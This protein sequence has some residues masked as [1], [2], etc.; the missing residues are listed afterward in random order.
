DHQTI[1][2]R[3]RRAPWSSDFAAE[4]LFRR[5]HESLLQFRRQ[6]SP[7]A[8]PHLSYCQILLM[9]IWKITT[10][11]PSLGVLR[12]IEEQ[13]R[14]HVFTHVLDRL[15]IPQRANDGVRFDR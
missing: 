13:R 15:S 2:L 4:Q 11:L 7:T 6:P 3:S 5:W 12:G 10:T 14:V 9:S 1:W 8:A